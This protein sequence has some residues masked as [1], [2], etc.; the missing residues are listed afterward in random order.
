MEGPVI[1]LLGAAVMIGW[2]VHVVVDG[3]R[4]RQ[5]LKVL[6]EFHSKL[7]DRIGTAREF[8]EFFNSEAGNRFLESLSSNEAGAPHLRILRSMQ[9]GLVLLALGL[10][11]RLMLLER[12]FSEDATDSLIVL[13]TAATAIG[14]AL[15]VSTALSYVLS[16]RLGLIER[17]KAARDQD[18][19]R[20]A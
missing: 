15:L 3:F 11:L 9:S 8:G 17:P 10:G 2:I 6:T 5:Q 4:R 20:S 19:S 16:K 13:A 14:F 12:M 1:V 18:V 7:L